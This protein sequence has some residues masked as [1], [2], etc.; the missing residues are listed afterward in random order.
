MMLKFLDHLDAADRLFLRVI[1]DVQPDEPA[2]EMPDQFVVA[3][4]I[5]SRYCD[6]SVVS[7]VSTRNDFSVLQAERGLGLVVASLAADIGSALGTRL[8]KKV[9]LQTND[10]FVG[11]LLLALAIALGAGL[12]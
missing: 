2:E 6:S 4:D 3:H 9:T 5:A 8:V 11:V 12:V 1:E 7:A 10:R